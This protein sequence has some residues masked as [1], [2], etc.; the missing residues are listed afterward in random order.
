MKLFVVILSLGYCL[1][2][3]V[4]LNLRPIIGVAAQ[5]TDKSNWKH[6]DSYIPAS[7][8]KYLQMAGANVVPIKIN[9]PMEYY[10]KLF[11]YLNG[12]LYPGGAVDIV[13]SGYARIGQIFFK[14][15]VQA[16]KKGDYFPM[17]GTCLGFELF[18]ALAVGKNVLKAAHASNYAIP[19]NISKGATTESRMFSHLPSDVLRILQKEAVTANFHHWALLPETYK[20]Y[21][22]LHDFFRVLS[23]NYDRKGVEFI[24]TMEAISY[25]FYG[26][27]WHPEKNVYDWNGKHTSPH[28][29][30]AIRIAQYFADFFVNEA[31]KSNHTFPSPEVEA[32][33][34]IDNLNP[35]FDGPPTFDVNYY[36]KNDSLY[37]F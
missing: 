34:R 33:Y 8:V 16:R 9:Q 19:L 4:A 7:Y 21:P 3:A 12:I 5:E 14:L 37:W 27:Q 29:P 13:N 36:F 17:W 20:Q 23:T 25:P 10:E 18:T 28:T 22:Q 30:N 11:S 24:S 26:T 15:A 6:G 32:M 35:I 2:S 31:R 1:N